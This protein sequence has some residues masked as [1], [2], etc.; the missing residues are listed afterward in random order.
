M[1][2]DYIPPSIP[3]LC[4]LMSTMS[5]FGV[6]FST[7]DTQHDLSS[8]ASPKGEMTSSFSWTSPPRAQHQA[9][10]VLV[11]LHLQSSIKSFQCQCV[12]L[13][14]VSPS[15]QPSHLISR[16]GLI[17]IFKKNLLHLQVGIHQEILMKPQTQINSPR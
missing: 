5:P 15:L 4:N 3:T 16:F 10:Y 17:C 9:L 6:D 7:E 14:F 13:C 1:P 11:T 12:K 8:L 2:V